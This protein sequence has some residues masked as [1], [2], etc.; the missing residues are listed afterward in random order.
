MITCTCRE[1]KVSALTKTVHNFAF[2]ILVEVPEFVNLF[3][4]FEE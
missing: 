2:S 1:Q 3:E 4:I